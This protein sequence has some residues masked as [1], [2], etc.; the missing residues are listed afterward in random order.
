MFVS[1]RNNEISEVNNLLDNADIE[2]LEG[3]EDNEGDIVSQTK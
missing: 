2:I 1:V 3:E